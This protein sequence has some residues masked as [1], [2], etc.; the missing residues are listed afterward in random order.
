MALQKSMP[1]KKLQTKARQAVPKKCSASLTDRQTGKKPQHS[2]PQ[3]APKIQKAVPALSSP[4]PASPHQCDHR[5]LPEN[6]KQ[7]TPLSAHFA[8]RHGRRQV[9]EKGRLLHVPRTQ[10]QVRCK[11]CGT[12]KQRQP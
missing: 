1:K 6:P 8:K 5:T 9:S 11:F 3:L 10:V 12:V 2:P 7:R 4:T